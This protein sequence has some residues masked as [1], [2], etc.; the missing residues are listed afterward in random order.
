MV[1]KWINSARQLLYPGRCHLC[2]APVPGE[3]P[4]CEGCRDDLPWLESACPRCALPLAPGSPEG[5]CAACLAQP[6]ALDGCHALFAYQAPVDRWIHA[7]KFRD[8][9]ATGR[10]LGLLLAGRLPQ[11]A[12]GARL[13]PVPLH[14]RRLR[15]RGYNQAAEI[16]RPLLQR[17]WL[18]SR[19]G[20]YRKRHTDA[21]SALPAHHRR[22]NLQGA[23]AVRRRPHGEHI[24]L[25]DDVMT[26]GSTLNELAGT[27]KAAG[28]E[29]VD[30]WVIART[31]KPG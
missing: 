5:C 10:L 8:D 27:L 30:A 14:P 2:L 29:R 23:F 21:Q 15:E 9:L 28:A 24:L 7:L 22:D 17:C 25:I 4:L 31:L 18:S 16:I 3:L 20:C 11:P 1:Y 26:T 13:L 6:P 19:C 12:A